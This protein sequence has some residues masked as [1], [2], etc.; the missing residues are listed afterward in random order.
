VEKLGRG[1]FDA[2]KSADRTGQNLSSVLGREAGFAS[3]YTI[4]K[5]FEGKSSFV[6]HEFQIMRAELQ[7]CFS[8]A[9]RVI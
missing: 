4:T 2:K 1:S 6:I 8:A 5:W 9:S 7:V 3:D